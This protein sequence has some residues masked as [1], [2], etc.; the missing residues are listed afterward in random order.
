LRPERPAGLDAGEKLEGEGLMF[1]GEQGTILADFV[2]GRPRLIPAAKMKAFKEP[3]KTLPRSPGNER[4]WLDAILDR[5]QVTGAGFAFSAV[6]TEVLCLANMAIRS[7]ERLAWDTA[8]MKVAGPAE[9]Q[10]MVSPPARDG[11][12]V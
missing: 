2:G 10:A 11:W 4:E 7:G 3:P 6:V 5:K 12:A 9:A 8:A 1:V